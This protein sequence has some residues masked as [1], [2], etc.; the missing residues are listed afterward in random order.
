MQNRGTISIP[1]TKLGEVLGLA[2]DVAIA[3]AQVELSRDRLVVLVTGDRF[4]PV[5]DGQQAPSH[6]LADLRGP[7]AVRPTGAPLMM[8]TNARE[9]LRQIRSDGNDH[10]CSFDSALQLMDHAIANLNG[11]TL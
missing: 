6:D 5:P 1:L 4:A 3:A 10:P 11:E 7:L 2:D 8:L 9:I